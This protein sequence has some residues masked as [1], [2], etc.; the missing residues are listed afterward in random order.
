MNFYVE[1]PFGTTLRAEKIPAGSFTPSETTRAREKAGTR[2]GVPR[3][4]ENRE[5]AMTIAHPAGPE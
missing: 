4:G 3:L 5:T 2:S 1:D